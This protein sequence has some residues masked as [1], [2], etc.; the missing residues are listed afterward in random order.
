MGSEMCIRDRDSLG[1]D[2]EQNADGK[3]YVANGELG[4]VVRNEANYMHV[5]LQSPDRLVVVPR[6][7]QDDSQE[8]D[9]EEATGTGCNWDL[10][11]VLSVHKM[12]GS[13]VPVAIVMIDEAPS[14][15]RLCDRAWWYTALSRAKQRCY[16]IGKLPVLFGGLRRQSVGARKTFLKELVRGD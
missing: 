12:Q 7:Q 3:V 14:A 10:G 2:A 5:A 4:R 15:A 16:L 1:E 11:Y 8:G 13:E 6:G 9:D